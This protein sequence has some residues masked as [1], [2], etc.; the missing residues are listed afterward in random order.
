MKKK[1]SEAIYDLQC[2]QH[3]TEKAQSYKKPKLNSSCCNKRSYMSYERL[4][5]NGKTHCTKC[6]KE[7]MIR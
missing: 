1:L 5:T 7:C 2:I 3:D 6:Q 4:P